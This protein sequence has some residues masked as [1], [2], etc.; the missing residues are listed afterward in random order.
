MGFWDKD[1][2]IP[3]K[4]QN[5]WKEQEENN[6]SKTGFCCSRGP[7]KK[8][9]RYADTWIETIETTELIRSIKI[10]RRFLVTEETSMKDH[11]LKP[12]GKPRRSKIIIIQENVERLRKGNLKRETEFLLIATQNNAMR[13]NQIKA[14]TDKTPQN[15]KCR[16]CGDRNETINHMI[17]ECS[18]LAQ[19]E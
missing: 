10:R 9:K 16:L 1:Y 8:A 4:N 2:L 14:R 11:R 6:L 19:K 15:R 5:K 18:I 17:S 12:V 3:P 7:P 13:T